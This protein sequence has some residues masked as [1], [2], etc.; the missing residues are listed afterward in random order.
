MKNC[1]ITVDDINRAENIFG[2]PIPLL[3]GKM[4]M[5]TQVAKTTVRI[6]LSLEFKEEHRR[7]TLFIDIF[8]VNKMPFL[9]CKSEG[10]EHFKVFNLNSRSKQV[11]KKKLKQVKRLYNKRGFA[12]NIAYADNEFDNDEVKDSFPSAT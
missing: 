8:Y 5:P 6:P 9:L 10:V 4:T 2:K 12:I 3:Q 1:R 7:V 11:I